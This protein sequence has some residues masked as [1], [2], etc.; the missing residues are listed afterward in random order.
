MWKR[1]SGQHHAR[2][3]RQLDSLQERFDVSQAVLLGSRDELEK[4]RPRVQCSLSTEFNVEALAGRLCPV[5]MSDGTVALFSLAEHVGSDQ[6]DELLRRLVQKGYRLAEPSRFVLDAPLLLAVA[7]NQMNGITSHDGTNAAATR[8][9]RTALAAAF[10]DLIEWGVRHGASDLHLNVYTDSGESEVK[11]T[12]KGRY[13][14]PER[15]RNMPTQMLTDM[16]SVVWMDIH[17][18]NGAVFDPRTEQQG[19]LV[20]K[21]DGVDVLIR[22]ASLAADAGPSVCLRL[23]IQDIDP[24]TSDLG[25]LGYLPQQVADIERVMVSEGG[26]IVFAG[27]VGSGKSTT[28]ASLISRIPSH[29]KIITIEDPVEYR[30]ANAIQ[31]T[32]ARALSDAQPRAYMAKLRTLKRS[33]MSD[34]LLG[35]IRDHESGQAFLDLAG[36]GVNVYTTVHAPS[37]A[38]VPDRLASDFIGVS[39]DFLLT[40]GVLRLIVYQA[41]IMRL[42]PH[43]SGPVSELGAGDYE[44]NGRYRSGR[45]WAKWLERIEK[46]YQIDTSTMRI[47]NRSG[48]GH[49]GTVIHERKPALGVRSADAVDTTS[50]VHAACDT[51]MLN[52]YCGRMVAAELI[53]PSLQ[54]GYL[55]SVRS[56]SVGQWLQEQ[57]ARL[58]QQG[59]QAP[60]IWRNAMDNAVLQALQGHIDPR[61]IE[62]HFLAFETRFHQVGMAGRIPGSAS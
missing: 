6:A 9:S 61:D 48:C 38:I 23:L 58:A 54:P 4:L 30:I 3:A 35:E 56:D 41:L 1:L 16:L 28:L 57:T 10:Q 59:L 32:V 12:I 29:R 51:G 13:L 37:A 2:R 60:T 44:I 26:A 39:R 19:S 46:T 62:R 27:T 43:C 42:C 24:E 15:F 14:A 20:R 33:A 22:W 55:D 40:P 11:Y 50:R 53:E 8:H 25:S 49:C 5:L 47:R 45:E 18:G 21:V 36:S 7:R 34:V 17:G 31:N 52:G